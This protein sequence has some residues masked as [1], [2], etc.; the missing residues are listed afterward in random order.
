MRR[1]VVIAVISAA[2]LLIAGIIMITLFPENEANPETTPSPTPAIVREF[3]DLIDVLHTDVDS[4]IMIP[5]GRTPYTLQLDH[6]HPEYWDIELV[7]DDAIFPGMQT[8]MYAVFSYATSMTRLMR[9]AEDADNEQLALFG[10]DDPVLIWKV[11]LLDGSSKEFELGLRLFDGSGNYVRSTDSRDVYILDNEAVLFLT[12]EIEDLYDIFFFPY[13]PSDEENYTWELIGHFLLEKPDGTV[14]EVVRRTDEE[15]FD[16]PYG[17]SRFRLLEPFEGEGSAHVIQSI[18]MEPVTH[19]TPE[20]VVAVRPADL[21]LYGLDTP[22]RLTVS[23]AEW[24]G[25]LLIGNRNPE[26]RGQYIMIEGFDAVLFDPHGTYGFLDMDPQQL[27]TQLTWVHHIED[28]SSVV[29]ELDGI[30]RML[31]I[32]HPAPGSD[33]TLKGWLD[34]IELNETN[35]RRL[36]ASA[37]RIMSTG[38]STEPVPDF[39][40]VYRIT[41]HF[42]FGGSQTLALYNIGE[43]HYLMVLNN[44]SLGVYTTRLQI[45]TNLLSRFEILDDGGD[46][47]MG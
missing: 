28:V 44:E 21:S 32:E 42:N 3:G 10:F 26:L 11:N 41:M 15:W 12:L 29:F 40:P 13:P 16:M 38:D 9:V 47:P 31:R 2:L 7:A 19:I 33:D 30:T 45:Q 25:T 17:F 14:I 46:L 22:A 36:F 23:T 1:P 6:T 5:G 37:M 43:S 27:R 35:T 20:T 34:D 4:V 18:L 39:S 24:E 8:I